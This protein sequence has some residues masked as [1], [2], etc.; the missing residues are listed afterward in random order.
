MVLSTESGLTGAIL[1]VT[2]GS[3]SLECDC[4]C[5]LFPLN[6]AL[7]EVSNKIESN[8]RHEIEHKSSK[9]AIT[10]LP[11]RP[12]RPPLPEHSNAAY[13]YLNVLDSRASGGQSRLSVLAYDVPVS[14]RQAKHLPLNDLLTS[15]N[16]LSFIANASK[17]RNSRLSPNVDL[18]VSV[19]SVTSWVGWIA[20]VDWLWWVL[21]EL[22][23]TW[24]D[25]GFTIS[26]LWTRRNRVILNVPAKAER[27]AWK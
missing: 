8:E 6:P 10:Y 17:V 9:G 24:S 19:L 23:T 22:F 13:W 14:Y 11:R 7:F 5:M 27:S 2:I 21:N 15:S 1:W 16:S 26:W 20:D 4:P 12:T 25:W 18:N 3:A